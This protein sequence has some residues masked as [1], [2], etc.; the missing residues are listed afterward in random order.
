M[1]VKKSILLGMTVTWHDYQALESVVCSA[2]TEQRKCLITYANQHVLNLAYAD[3]SIMVCYDKFDIVHPDGIGVRLADWIVYGKRHRNGKVNGTDFYSR[4]GDLAISRKYKIF[5]FGGSEET[6]A[7]LKQKV[8]PEI[9][10]GACGGF[11]YENNKLIEKI[12]GSG[13]DIL[14]VGLGAPKQEKWILENTKSV[15][16]PV[17]IGVGDGLRVFT[18]TKVRGPEWVR[19]LG[20]EWLVRLFYEPSRLWKRYLIGIPVFLVRVFKQRIFLR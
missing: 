6:S 7:L 18:N 5:F 12:N 11:S 19:A 16:T 14:L 1:D 2:I 15:K 17:I 10:S 9:Y 20:L 13:A 8:R 3:S 4:L